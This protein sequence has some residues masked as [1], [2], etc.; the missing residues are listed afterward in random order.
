MSGRV[1]FSR[2]SRFPDFP[3]FPIS[4]YGSTQRASHKNAAGG[5]TGLSAVLPPHSAE[6]RAGAHRI[7]LAVLLAGCFVRSSELAASF[8]R[9]CRRQ[10]CRCRGKN[11]NGVKATET[12]LAP[13]KRYA[14]AANVRAV[15]RASRS[16]SR[17]SKK[18]RRTQDIARGF[19][20]VGFVLARRVAPLSIC[21]SNQG[22]PSATI[23]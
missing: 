9:C 23:A 14:T 16:R 3:I 5:L 20:V 10:C 22:S 4:R 8:A 11:V 17:T 2:V 1:S 12:P 13:T 18:G 7:L 19:V 6:R 21:C 15:L